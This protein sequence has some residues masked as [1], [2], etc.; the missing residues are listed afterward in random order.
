MNQKN[1]NPWAI[2]VLSGIFYLYEYVL[3]VSPQ[4]VMHQLMEQFQIG[5]TDFGLMTSIY[6][7]AYVPLQAPCG[8]ILD[9]L[10]VRYVI[11]GSSL[12]CALGALIFTYTD[13]LAIAYLGRF[14]MGVGSACA[15]VG[16]MKVG[17][18]WFESK[19]FPL[20]AGLALM[21]GQIGASIGTRP[22]A[23]LVYS[24]NYI[25]AMNV[26]IALGGVISV[27]AYIFIPQKTAVNSTVEHV[28]MFSSLKTVVQSPIN[29]VLGLYGL[30][31][32]IPISGFAELWAIPF[33]MT[34]TTLPCHIVASL[35][36]AFFVGVCLGSPI[37]S[38]IARGLNIPLLTMA[39]LGLLGACLS[40]F[41][42]YADIT[43][44]TL[45][46]MLFLM[47]VLCGGH[48]LCFVK[49]KENS[50]QALNGTTL[51][52]I[53]MVVM[54]S[55]LIC[56][57]LIGFLL[58]QQWNGLSNAKGLRVYSLGNFEYALSTV[59]IAYVAATCL[60]FLF[61]RKDIKTE[62]CSIYPLRIILRK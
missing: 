51:G 30:F 18:D 46:I 4:V 24:Y 12:M 32:Y 15:Y 54:T 8:Y 52:F 19:K 40:Y 42:L 22:F 41:V 21:M 14:L 34:K 37:I 2:W 1:I 29:W 57:P 3:R 13:Q 55:G 25:T 17:T 33:L 28:N 27:I 11:C 20:I 56:Q 9:R 38:S 35:P 10:G 39:T 60:I 61:F 47:G 62:L 44:T 59:F 45:S 5:G 53:N 50:P 43:C 49:A 36:I 23:A 58:D 7:M 26:F 16:C 31:M 48:V 6:Y